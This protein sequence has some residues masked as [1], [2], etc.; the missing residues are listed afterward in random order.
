MIKR[1]VLHIGSEKTGTTFLARALDMIAP[2]ILGL[3]ILYP[4]LDCPTV[5]DHRA[6]AIAVS[7]GDMQALAGQ[8]TA[9]GEMVTEQIHT[10]ILSSE[11]FF[12][13]LDESVDAIRAIDRIRA[14]AA[15]LGFSFEIIAYLRR[16]DQLV[17][18]LY[19]QSIKWD[20]LT[21]SFADWVE[22]IYDR[23]DYDKLMRQ[24][25][26]HC[27]TLHV[28]IYEK[29]AIRNDIVINF[30]QSI[31]SSDAVI[32]KVKASLNSKGSTAL[33]PI[34]DNMSLSDSA[35]EM[36]HTL[37]K[38]DP[39]NSN[40]INDLIFTHGGMAYYQPPFA[41]NEA[42]DQEWQQ[43]ITDRYRETNRRLAA[44][45]GIGRPG[46]L[47]AQEVGPDLAENTPQASALELMSK[48]LLS[49]AAE[50]RARMFDIADATPGILL[51]GD[52][53]MSLWFP[54]GWCRAD[55]WG[56]WTLAEEADIVIKTSGKTNWMRLHFDLTA[57]V[58]RDHVQ[59]ANLYFENTQL[60]RWTFSA[61]KDNLYS[62]VDVDLDPEKP[63]N[64]L[65]LHI[66]FC[67]SPRS[68]GISTDHRALGLGLRKIE[69]H[70]RHR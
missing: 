32:D 59:E 23:Y 4:K 14:W 30:L 10:I 31:N 42:L 65:R 63:V 54:R 27:D 2:D 58:P 6:I 37:L 17:N 64:T 60:A 19:K 28:N 34:T 69:I 48:L 57:F 68:F 3:G 22:T 8:L 24:W 35:I 49:V 29:N 13:L 16:Q 5:E 9:I 7:N 55:T 33:Y 38:F 1:L 61:E 53:S 21:S 51:P 25:E 12:H 62:V 41:S 45:L 56:A 20:S 40:Y 47:F 46:T 39:A 36:I 18:S 15:A 67:R 70:T 43:R 52:P 66:P 50:N 26:E 44:R 11:R